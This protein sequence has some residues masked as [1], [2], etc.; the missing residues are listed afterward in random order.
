MLSTAY[1]EFERQMLEQIIEDD[2]LT[3][4]QISH[5]DRLWEHI[6]ASKETFNSFVEHVLDHVA[7]NKHRMCYDPEYDSWYEW[8]SSLEYILYEL[9]ARQGELADHYLC[10]KYGNMFSC[11]EE[12][13]VYG[14]YFF[15]RE[16]GQGSYTLIKKMDS[17][18]LF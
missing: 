4:I 8:N 11:D 3:R 7:R 14:N 15:S 10:E 13:Y 5:M 18:D 9:A 1:D 2:R 16:H 12:S 17:E 6:S